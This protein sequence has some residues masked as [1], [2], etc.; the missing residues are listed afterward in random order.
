MQ[1]QPVIISMTVTLLEAGKWGML[2]AGAALKD[3]LQIFAGVLMSRT[4]IEQ[5]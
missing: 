4:R 3:S 5:N 2:I 1:Y